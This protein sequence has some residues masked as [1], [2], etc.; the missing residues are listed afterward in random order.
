MTNDFAENGSKTFIEQRKTGPNGDTLLYHLKNYRS[1]DQIQ[2]MF[3]IIFDIIFETARRYNMF[4]KPVDIAIDFTEWL[5]YG[6]KNAPMVVEKKPE[7]GTTHCYKFATVNIVEG[8][9][10]FTLFALPVGPFDRKESILGKLLRYTSKKVKIRKIYVDRGF[11]DSKS[12]EIFDRH[13]IKFLMPCTENPRIK[14]LLEMTP[15]PT[16]IKDYRMGATSF[17]IVITEDEQGIKRAFATN[18]DFNENDA[19]LSKRLFELYAKR[20]GIETSYRVKKHSFRPKTTSKNYFIRLFYFMLSVLLYNLWIL[21]DILI[22][23]S[24]FGVKT[25][26][27]IITSKYFNTVLISIDLGG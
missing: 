10:R 23:L 22:C 9:K 20:W 2:E 17:N 21:I 13:R 16:I 1:I 25:S 8:D 24:L 4:K 14:K 6:D 15:S 27:H 11:F 18:I 5:F 26:K 19:N 12:I 3:R 7:R